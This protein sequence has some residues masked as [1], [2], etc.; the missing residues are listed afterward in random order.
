MGEVIGLVAVI[1]FFTSL[2]VIAYLFF[3]SRHKQRMALIQHGQ[4]ASIFKED[5]DL[6][7]N[8]KY[9]MVAVGVGLGLFA[10]HFFNR[11]GME[12]GPAY[13]GMMLILGGAGLILYYALIARKKKEGDG[14]I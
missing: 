7:V 5:A 1:G 13:F 12:E 8:L 9:G 3:N 4:D 10:G 2:I 6:N 11:M 14:I